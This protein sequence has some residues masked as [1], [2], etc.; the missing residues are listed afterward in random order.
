MYSNLIIQR[1]PKKL[2]IELLKV[3][4]LMGLSVFGGC[5]KITSEP[6]GTMP[7]VMDEMGGSQSRPSG[8]EADME[9]WILLM[10]KN[11]KRVKEMFGMGR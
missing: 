1:S 9:G 10:Q 7:I 5:S 3:L 8:D 2:Q 11:R 6:S 4:I